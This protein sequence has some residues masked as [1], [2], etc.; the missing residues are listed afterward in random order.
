MFVAVFSCTDCALL[1]YECVATFLLVQL[2]FLVDL[3]LASLLSAVGVVFFK[4]LGQLTWRSWAEVEHGEV[5]TTWK[6]SCIEM[7]NLWF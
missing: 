3:F 4:E 5:K 7:R 2:F 1:L 6:C